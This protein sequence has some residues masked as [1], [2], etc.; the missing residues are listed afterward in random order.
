MDT[1]SLAEAKAHLSEILNRVE[2]GEE[3]II[4]RHGQPIARLAGLEKPK[5]PLKPL[6]QFR[7]AMPRW[8]SASADLVRAMR[9]EES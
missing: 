9:D 4:T 7:S 1:V 2:A 6:R 8:R 5:L 3:V